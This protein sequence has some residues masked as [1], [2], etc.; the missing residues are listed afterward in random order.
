[1]HPAFDAHNVVSAAEHGATHVSLVP[2]TLS[3]IDPSKFQ[4]VLL[5]GARAPEHIAP[6]VVTTYGMTE[7][8]GGVFY[9]DTALDGVECKIEDS[10][11]FLRGPMLLRAYRDETTPLTQDGWLPTGDSGTLTDGH[12]Q[13]NGRMSDMIITGGENV[14]PNSVERII[15][16]HPNVLESAVAGVADNEWGERVVAWIV[17]HEALLAPSLSEIRD[18]VAKSLPAF[19]CPKEIR[20]IKQLPTTSLGK[21]DRKQLATTV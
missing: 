21:V 13:V 1:M 5:G 18:L 8:F 11:I 14:W 7:T 19:C 16:Q 4:T 9:N 2:T 3:R 20:I 15:D 10:Q 17:L 6:N 12:L